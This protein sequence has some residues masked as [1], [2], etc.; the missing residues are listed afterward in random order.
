VK[1]REA[2][3]WSA[4]WLT[5]ALGFAGLIFFWHGAD[6]SLQFVTGYLVE[7]SLSV[8]NLF[9]FLL[10]FGYFQVPGPFQ[11]RVLFWGILGALVMRA[12]FI[13]AGIALLALFHWLIYV[14]GAFLILTGIKLLFEKGK[15]VRPERNPVLR[16]TRRL[17]PI[18]EQYDGT[19]FFVRREGVLWATP[20]LVV[21]VVIETTDVIFAVDSI[22]AI[23]AISNDPFIVYSSNVFAVLGLR[24]LYFA[25]AGLMQLFHFLH[26]GLALVLAF[27]GV[28]MLLSDTDY[29][30]PIG[31]TLAV[32]CGVLTISVILSVLL[33]RSAIIVDNLDLSGSADDRTGPRHEEIRREDRGG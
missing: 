17:V 3:A 26:Y 21:L 18:T 4:V 13:V 1:V 11:H 28:K 25:L 22:P 12:V 14:F 30:I 23:L 19:R 5:L 7:L 8:D 24:S 32:V 15:K 29:R 31:I 10:I 20:L 16:L 27:V 33:P 6:T 9:V 2:L